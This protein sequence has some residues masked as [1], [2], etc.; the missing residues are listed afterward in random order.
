MLLQTVAK[1]ES[2]TGWALTGQ[3]GGGGAKK[4]LLHVHNQAFVLWF[5]HMVTCIDA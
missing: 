2:K 1:V 5:Q 3:Y 4:A